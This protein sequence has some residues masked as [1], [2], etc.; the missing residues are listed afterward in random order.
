MSKQ[1]SDNPGERATNYLPF[2]TN[3]GYKQGLASVGSRDRNAKE[4]P[5][6]KAKEHRDGLKTD[7]IR[8]TENPPNLFTPEAHL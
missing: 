2:K 1:R 8:T 3:C 6:K 5:S 4:T 7:Q